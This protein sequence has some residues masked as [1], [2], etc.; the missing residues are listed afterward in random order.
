MKC[1][2]KAI[3]KFWHGEWTAFVNGKPYKINPH[4]KLKKLNYTVKY[5]AVVNIPEDT[6]TTPNTVCNLEK[7]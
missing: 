7:I 3:V 5:N 6:F 1:T 2:E 4:K